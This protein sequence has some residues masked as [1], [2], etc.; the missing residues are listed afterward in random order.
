MA[1]NQLEDVVQRWVRKQK[2]KHHIWLLQ[3]VFVIKFVYVFTSSSFI[4]VSF[5]MHYDND[6]KGHNHSVTCC[7][8]FVR[9]TRFTVSYI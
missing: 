7:E 6:Y 2:I 1:A 4:N 3:Y 8:W 5:I 9:C